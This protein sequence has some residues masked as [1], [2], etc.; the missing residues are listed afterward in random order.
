MVDHASDEQTPEMWG[1]GGKPRDQ[2]PRKRN[3]T[4]EWRRGEPRG[5][6]RGRTS[7]QCTQKEGTGGPARSL[8]CEG[9]KQ[10]SCQDVWIIKKPHNVTPS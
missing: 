8:M 6:K 4:P 10:F 3:C 7:T 2:R 1:G 5:R 9:S